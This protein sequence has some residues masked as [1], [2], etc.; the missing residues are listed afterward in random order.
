VSFF[1]EVEKAIERE[2]RRWTV[3]AFGPA[4]SD[5]L[6]LVHR[7]ILDEVEGKVQTVQRGKRVFPYNHL[8][9][10]LVSPDASRRA[11]F[12]AA[13]AGEDRRLECDL[14]ECLAGAGCDVPGGFAVEI[15]TEEEGPRGFEILYEMGATPAR[16]K[17]AARL[18]V[19][20]GKANQESFPLAGE[21]TNIGRRAELTDS[22][23]RVIRRN[24]VVFE[25]GVDEAN[26]TVSRSHAHVRLDRESAE[27]R[28][29]DDSSE[30]GTRIFRAGRSIEVPP[31]RTRGERLR[32][33]D[34]IYL[35]RA[36]LRFEQ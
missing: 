22:L 20:R 19:V 24:D 29:C 1:S 4:E 5:E 2:F 36:C 13:F 26:A 28:I 14:R 23:E 21:R 18:V 10:R 25:E 11:L 12:Q 6:L 17:P 7:A 35:G 34:E 33:G 15:E 3:K 27:Y 31:G 32:S 16:V 9:V 8:R 30:Y